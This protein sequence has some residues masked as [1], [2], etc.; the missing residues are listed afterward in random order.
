MYGNN[1]P[2]KYIDP[3][4]KNAEAYAVG[5]GVLLIG[6]Y[7]IYVTSGP[8]QRAQIDRAITWIGERASD[9]MRSL[10]GSI[11]NESSEPNEGPSAS[12][13]IDPKDVAGKNPGEIDQ[14]AR[15]RGLQPKGPDPKGGKGS[16]VDP[17]TGEQRILCHPNCSNPHAHV[18]DPSGNR[19]DI[20]GNPVPPESPE[21]HIPI[22]SQ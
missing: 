20:N 9:R 1:N 16:Y 22:Q 17:T 14:L 12:P 10:T 11:F 15:E 21:A 2:Y 6:G 7:I 5:T 18:N 3:D 8:E 19:L 13:H 4:G